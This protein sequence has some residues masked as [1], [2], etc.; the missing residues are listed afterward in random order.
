M[1]ASGNS[2]TTGYFVGAMTVGSTTLTAVGY[3]DI[4]MIK[5]DPSGSPVWAKGFGSSS[6]G[7]NYG[8]SIA[9]DASGNSYTTGY[10]T[11]TM[12]V[13][14]TA[15]T[16]VGYQD[17]FMIKLDPSGSPVWA[18]GFG[19]SS[20]AIGFGIAVDASGDSY[21]TGY[22]ARTMT[23]G[24]T[25]LTAVGNGDIFMIKLDSSGS[26]V[27]A[28]GFGGSSDKY[29][30]GIAVD[31]SGNSYTTGYYTG[32][33]TVGS[34]TLTAVS[35]QDIFMIKLDSSGS[36]VWAKGFGSS[37]SN[38]YAGGFGIAV[39]ASGNSYTTGSFQGTMTVGSTSITAGN[40]DI[41]M[42]KLD[43]SGSPVWAKGFGSSTKYNSNDVGHGIAVDASGNSYTTGVF[44]GTM[45]MGS[46]TLTAVGGY[47]IFIVKLDSW[48][49]PVWAKGFGNSGDDVGR[50]IAMDASGNS[51]A[52]GS[53]EGTMTVG[54]TTLTA[55]GWADIFMIKLD[56]SGG[57]AS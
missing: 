57:P 40:Q 17:I 53:F 44:Q 49:S 30:Q 32:T 26:P 39:D 20:Y 12:T 14:S 8:H 38:S 2:Y 42:I 1:D 18:K 4:F 37:S 5:L 36:P 48:G 9:V 41:F 51:Y 16:A 6:D 54:S 43:S 34:T 28:K 25:T 47:D 27:W 15:L 24:S 33:L 7:A 46:T 35:G 10:F 21:T 52:S 45:T 19:S 22:F 11:G 3:Q 13:G 23:V 56:P 31:A 29:G 55:V 50:G